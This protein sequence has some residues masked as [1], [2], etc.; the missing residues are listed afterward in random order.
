MEVQRF[1]W[2]F[3]EEISVLMTKT[4]GKSLYFLT[5]FLKTSPS[6]LPETLSNF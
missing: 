1:F 3:V 2:G 6:I 5:D 4:V